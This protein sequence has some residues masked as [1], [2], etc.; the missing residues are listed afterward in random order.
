[1]DKDFLS[2]LVAYAKHREDKGVAMAAKSLIKLFREMDPMM[3]PAKFRGRHVQTDKKIQ[4]FA[5]KAVSD[6]IPG[7]ETL[8][9]R[10]D[11]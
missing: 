4:P 11:D 1:M 8:V 3:L 9:A 7:M 2:D 10:G 6:T 5:K